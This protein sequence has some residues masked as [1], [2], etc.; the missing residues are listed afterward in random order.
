MNQEHED[1]QFPADFVHHDHDD[2]DFQLLTP[3][4]TWGIVIIIAIIFVL[5]MMFCG[6]FY[7]WITQ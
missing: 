5:W 7:N 3:L 4:E 6:W 2:E 1:Q